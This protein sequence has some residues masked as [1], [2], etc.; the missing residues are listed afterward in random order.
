MFKQCILKI[1]ILQL[2]YNNVYYTP[3]KNSVH[4]NEKSLTLEY[5]IFTYEKMSVYLE[6]SV[7]GKNQ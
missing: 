2:Y 7:T 1:I 4:I 5:I 3:S 6:L